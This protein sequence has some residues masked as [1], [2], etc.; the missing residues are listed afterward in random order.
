MLIAKMMTASKSIPRNCGME[1]FDSIFVRRSNLFLESIKLN[2][3]L[4]KSYTYIYIPKGTKKD[5]NHHQS[6]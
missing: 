3:F 4:A 5:R 2:A 1:S 6:A